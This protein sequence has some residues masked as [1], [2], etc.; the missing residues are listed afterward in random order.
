MIEISGSPLTRHREPG[1]LRRLLALKP[2][3]VDFDRRGFRT[4]SRSTREVLEAAAGAFLTGY[5]RELAGPASH[6]PDLSDLPEHRRGFA[7]EGA[8]MAAALLDLLN[9]AGGKRL[10]SVNRAHRDRHVYL[11]QVGVGWAMAK[12]RRRRLG[13]LG[14]DLPLLSWLAYDG[15]GFCQAYFASPGRL[16]RWAGHPT[17]P[18]PATCDI[19]YQGLG[20]SLWFH[21]CGD[22]DGVADFID[23]L[24]PRHHG[25]AWSGAALAASYAGGASPAAYRRLRERSGDQLGALAQ[26]AA[27]AA[28]AWRRSGHTP[29]HARTAVEI[30]AGTDLE[31]AADW[32]V[33]GRR[34][35]D[36]PGADAG[37]YRRWRLRIQQE[38]VELTYR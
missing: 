19:R 35:L 15:M 37:D 29:P 16:R 33:R 28:E 24:P 26:G 12:L 17:R 9:P 22:P 32:T 8:A 13:R 27:F 6:A 10:D 21:E 5:N 30:L 38:A 18:C 31:D 11:I 23:I 3:L 2:S 25:D 4:T 36:H 1:G 7:A 34:G 20:R 14:A